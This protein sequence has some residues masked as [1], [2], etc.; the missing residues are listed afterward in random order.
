[1]SEARPEVIIFAGPNGSGKST[2]TRF[3]RISGLYINAD[4]IKAS[5]HC[6]D[7][8]AAIK[9]EELREWALQEHKS[10]TFETVLSTDQNLNLL[11]RAKE[12]GYFVRGIY[13]FTRDPHINIARVRARVEDGGHPVPEE[14]IVSRYYKSLERIPDFVNVCDICHVFDNSTIPNRIYKKWLEEG[15]LWPCEDWTKENITKLVLK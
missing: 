11:K 6:S 1:M 3:S 14:K 7:L 5:I 15:L 8:E 4:N 12:V 9:A 13:V 2:L 10:F